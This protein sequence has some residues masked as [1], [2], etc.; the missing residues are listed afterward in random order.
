MRQVETPVLTLEEIK[1][2]TQFEE[3]VASYFR[4]IKKENK[5]LV[6]VDVKPPAVGTDG[7]R[8]I[9]IDFLITDGIKEFRR[10]W[11]VQCKFHKRNISTD[12]ISDINI[13]TLIHSYKASGYLLICKQS[14][15][16]KLTAM[17]ERLNSDCHHKYQYVIWSGEFFRSLLLTAEPIIHKTFFPKFQTSIQQIN[18]AG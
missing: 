6:W 3:L 8:D 16:N 11:I 12:E 7:G 4:A 17:F 10:R 9:L 15:T 18:G 14:P 13:P 2:A 5:S 1:D